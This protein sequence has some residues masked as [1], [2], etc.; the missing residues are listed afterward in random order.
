MVR[1]P[2]TCTFQ[3]SQP[4]CTFS[5]LCYLAGGVPIEGCG[6]DVAMTCCMLYNG[7]H[8]LLGSGLQQHGP[9]Q[10]HPHHPHLPPPPPGHLQPAP[11]PPH[12]HYPPSQLPP[13]PPQQLTQQLPPPP[14]LPQPQTAMVYMP[15]ASQ[16]FTP[17]TH[18]AD[19]EDNVVRRTVPAT[20]PPEQTYSEPRNQYARNFQGEDGKHKLNCARRPAT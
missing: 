14:P 10:H 20:V 15:Q 19:P 2:G 7:Q 8:S 3:R 16:H 13:P 12:H 6:G 4:A 11:Y 9:P 5:L 17:T 18:Y 1:H